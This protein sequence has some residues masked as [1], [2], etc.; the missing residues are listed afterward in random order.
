[1]WP[2]HPGDPT[3]P[4]NVPVYRLGTSFGRF[5]LF[6]PLFRFKFEGFENLPSEG[7]CLVVT[8]HLSN[9]D[10]IIVATYLPRRATFPAKRE[11][12]S[13]PVL[14]WLCRG[15][16]LIPVRRDGLDMPALRVLLRVCAAESAVGLFPEGTRSRKGVLSQPLAGAAYLAVKTGAPVVPLAIWG[17]EKYTKRGRLRHG[18]FP[19][20]LRMGA[21][22][23]LAPPAGP[24]RSDTLAERSDEIM[25][26]IAD[27]MPVE[28]HGAYGAAAPREA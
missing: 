13:V 9:W 23:R 3:L 8:N 14:G 10:P 20:R 12:F 4:G 21:P 7:R 26:R 18:R 25:R 6:P 19:V 2:L 22:F 28:Y 1:M 5:I 24:L 11:I 27:L 17:T 16:G 15:W